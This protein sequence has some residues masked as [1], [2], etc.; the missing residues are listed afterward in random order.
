MRTN[1]RRFEVLLPRQFNDGSEI[2]GEWISQ[3]ILEVVDHFGAVSHETH[4]VEGH[5]H[6]GGVYYRDD[7]ARIVVDVPDKPTNRQWMKRYKARW[8]K[9]LR[10]LELWMVSYH[11]EIE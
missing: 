7:L 6:R 2:P 4:N 8:R 9:K 10:Q 1:W 3:A 11:V 5:W